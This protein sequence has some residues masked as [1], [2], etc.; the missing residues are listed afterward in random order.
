MLDLWA[1]RAFCRQRQGVKTEARI[2]PPEHIYEN[3]QKVELPVW[4]LAG[5]NSDMDVFAVGLS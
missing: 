2:A 3:V 4:M 5:R 1:F